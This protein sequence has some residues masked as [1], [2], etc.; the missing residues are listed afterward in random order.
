MSFAL[1]IN[2]ILILQKKAEVFIKKCVYNTIFFRNYVLTH[3]GT[4][5]IINR[6]SYK[7]QIHFTIVEHIQMA[8]KI[9]CQHVIRNHHFKKF[10]Y[11]DN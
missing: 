11:I 1:L 6:Y 7:T 2:I 4:V 3:L 9:L 8:H 10:T 5:D